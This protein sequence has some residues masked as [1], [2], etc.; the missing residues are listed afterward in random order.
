MK[1][2]SA[3]VI[4]LL[5]T[6]AFL[7][8][9]ASAAASDFASWNE[10]ADA[11][12][13]VLDN[14][15]EIYITGDYEGARDEVNVAYY[16]FYE[17]I[18]YERVV[19]ASISGAR[20]VQVETQFKE[21]RKIMLAQVSNEEVREALDILINYLHEDANVLDGVSGDG[22]GG[23]AAG[24]GASSFLTSFFIILREGV[25][26]IIIVG[27]IVA[28]LIK[29][30]HKEKTRSVYIGSLLAIAASVLMAI[31]LNA[32]MAANTA[33]QEI[34][35]GCTMLL[36][37]CVLIYVSNWMVSKSESEVWSRYI[38]GKVA[39]S[40][41]R[42]SMFTLSFT[43]FLAVFREGAEVILFYQALIVAPGTDFRM[44]WVGFG[45]GCVVLVAVYLAIRLLSIRLPLK[46]FFLGTSWLLALMAVS[47]L[48][49]AIYE[50]Q[51]AD[52]IG[53]TIVQGVPT[54]EVLGIYPRLETLV[55]QLILLAITVV[56]FVI[57]M[58]RNKKKRLEIMAQSGP[59]GDAPPE[60]KD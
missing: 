15:Y 1:R 59:G 19:M 5:M 4:A 23:G 39:G 33:S 42:G 18:G 46:P 37:V 27:A 52:V 3:M 35:E 24:S 49:G 31:I 34:I 54:I 9:C 44:M 7:A 38:Q 32:A 58:N 17:A 55:P 16:S 8:P 45:V 20:G 21:C 53:A 50:L 12:E 48:G 14:S 29:S 51:E 47:F 6:V 36:A 43:A 28:Y 40:L 13:A 26:A 25:E 30:G 41:S 56:T 2:L 22:E 60:Q 57:Q 10:V 11:M